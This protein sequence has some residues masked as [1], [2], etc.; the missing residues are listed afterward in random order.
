ML[1]RSAWP[2]GHVLV[3]EA[4]GLTVIEFHGEIDIAAAL[5]ILPTLDTATSA[6]G[7]TVVLDL[8]PVEFFD[9]YALRLLC[10]AQDRV[11]ARGGLLLV[12][13]A[14]PPILKLLRAGGLL[15]R[16]APLPTVQEALARGAQ[17]A[18]G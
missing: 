1:E 14:Q 16:F 8:E 10:R 4:H 5:H 7:H 13:C 15:D 2:V 3:H 11:V 17:E 18:A 9:I 6:V 12:V